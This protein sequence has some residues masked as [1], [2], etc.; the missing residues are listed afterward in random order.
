MIRRSSRS[1]FTSLTPSDH[2]RVDHKP[3]QCVEHQQKSKEKNSAAWEK[4]PALFIVL[5]RLV[6]TAPPKFEQDRGK[7]LAGAK[8]K[9]SRPFAGRVLGASVEGTNYFSSCRSFR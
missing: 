2:E 3:K 9:N 6:H 7:L 1:A 4:W 5:V 8:G